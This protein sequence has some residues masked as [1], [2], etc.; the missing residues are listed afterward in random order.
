ML[1]CLRDGRRRAKSF[2]ICLFFYFFWFDVSLIFAFEFVL[3]NIACQRISFILI[4]ISVDVVFAREQEPTSFIRFCYLSNGLGLAKRPIYLTP[5]FRSAWRF[6]LGL[7]SLRQ[8]LTVRT[9]SPDTK[10]PTEQNLFDH[11]SCLDLVQTAEVKGWRG[12]ASQHPSGN[13]SMHG[14]VKLGWRY[15]ACLQ[16]ISS[17]NENSF[18]LPNFS[19]SIL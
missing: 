7:L 17:T 11:L 19:S 15:R 12:C 5:A 13:V 18:N 3:R 6:I 2:V 1:V 14:M 4:I 8:F 10:S 9:H 16:I